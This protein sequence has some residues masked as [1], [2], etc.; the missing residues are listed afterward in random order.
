MKVGYARV[1]TVGQALDAQMESLAATGCEKI[2]A[3]KLSGKAAD[4]REELQRTIEFVREGDAF[5]V[6]RLDR[7]AR[8]TADLHRIAGILRQKGVELIVLQQ[9]IDT[10]TPAGRLLFSMLGAIAEFERDL[11]NERASE[12]RARAKQRGVKF[13]RNAKLSPEEAAALKSEFEAGE[14]SK[15]QLAEKYGIGRATVYRLSR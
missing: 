1:S 15:E 2:F 3:E 5:V 14:F 10:G 9:N 7:L 11:I 13:G 4:V 8:S 6:T 12:G